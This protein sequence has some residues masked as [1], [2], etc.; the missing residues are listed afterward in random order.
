VSA[1]EILIIA[2]TTSP[3]VPWKELLEPPKSASLLPEAIG[4]QQAR[5]ISIREGG[6]T[7]AL[8]TDPAS[9]ANTHTRRQ[10]KELLVPLLHSQFGI[11]GVEW[12]ASLDLAAHGKILGSLREE[13]SYNITNEIF[14]TDLNIGAIL[15]PNNI[16]FT[17]K[18]AKKV[19]QTGEIA[20]FELPAKP[21]VEFISHSKTQAA[22]LSYEYVRPT[23][24]RANI[25]TPAEGN[26]IVRDTFYPGWQATIDGKPTPIKAFENIFR[27]IAVPS[28]AHTI[29]FRYIPK[30]L[31]MGIA[32]SLMTLL[33]IIAIL[34]RGTTAKIQLY[35]R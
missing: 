32:I 21:R 1:A 19:A 16:P 30:L 10:Q 12:P 29:E 24:L 33:C 13:N 4:S 8:F 27:S 35:L 34:M 11:S 9:R 3:T 5:I 15:V 18:L 23:L 7:G 20:I 22:A 28:G 17:P 25:T 26:L 31:Y 6:D 2:T 14:A